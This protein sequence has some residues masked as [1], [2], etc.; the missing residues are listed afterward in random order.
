MLSFPP[1]S[2]LVML[3]ARVSPVGKFKADVEGLLSSVGVI[4]T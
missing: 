2:G 3:L 4:E 1:D